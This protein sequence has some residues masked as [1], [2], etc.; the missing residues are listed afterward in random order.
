MYLLS[1]AFS[2]L[3]PLLTF[4]QK[5][6]R[7]K[8][9][10]LQ[11]ILETEFTSLCVTLGKDLVPQHLSSCS[12]CCIL[13]KQE[14]VSWELRV[15]I[16]PVPQESDGKKRQSSCGLNMLKLENGFVLLFSS[17]CCTLHSLLLSLR[18]GLCR[19]TCSPKPS[20]WSQGSFSP[21][22]LS[23]RPARDP[24]QA[25]PLTQWHSQ[26]R[27]RATE[28]FANLKDNPQFWIFMPAPLVS[29]FSRRTGKDIYN[30]TRPNHYGGCKVLFPVK[31]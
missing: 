12:F 7:K 21:Q 24:G 8:F 3:S 10:F 4:P 16:D 17:F 18:K 1:L 2:L 9:F 23:L 20:A 11:T 6:V 28:K 13:S 19:A 14:T 29:C 26:P 27:P 15:K 30:I 25:S 22:Q 31:N 5:Q